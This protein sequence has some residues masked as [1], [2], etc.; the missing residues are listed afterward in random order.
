M[1]EPPSSSE[2]KDFSILDPTP[3]GRVEEAREQESFELP[4]AAAGRHSDH[5]SMS[6]MHFTQLYENIGK[7]G[8]HQNYTNATVLP[9]T[10]SN[11]GGAAATSMMNRFADVTCT[12]LAESMF[13]PKNTSQ[14]I[15]IASNS[16]P[17]PAEASK[18]VVQSKETA[19]Q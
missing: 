9:T 19:L 6:D 16:K 4:M 14:S 1:L 15:L 7:N 3:R 12:E 2:L 17:R 11:E 5:V 8:Q 10:E 13:Q 18:E